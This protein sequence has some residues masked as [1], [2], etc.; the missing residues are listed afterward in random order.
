MAGSGDRRAERG[1]ATRAALVRAARELFSERG[2][3]AVGT[4]EVVER[5]GVT[6]GAM[7]HH[8]REKKDLMRAVY[9][10]TEQELVAATVERMQGV[11]DPW[12]RL[13]TG[14]RAFFDFCADPALSQIGLVDAPAVLGW[15]EWREVGRRYVFGAVTFVLQ[16]AM[17]KGVLRRADVTNLAHLF[18]AALGEAALMLG[19]ADDPEKARADV[20]A[21]LLTLLE[22]MRP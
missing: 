16:D 19:D 17:D 4:N 8:F 15:Q 13:V 7:Y 9:E 18:I 3:A 11:D 21:T 2:Y 12:E 1:E 6:R 22:G 20:E 5:A 14:V 10:Q